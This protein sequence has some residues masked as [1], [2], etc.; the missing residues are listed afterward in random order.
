M[1]A[2]VRHLP[3]WN[4]DR[5]LCIV[6]NGEIYNYREIARELESHGCRSRS[7]GDTEVILNAVRTWGIEAA[8]RKFIGMFAFAIWSPR[9]GK[10]TLVRDRVGVKPLFYW[11]DSRRVLFGSETRALM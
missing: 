5:S 8:V 1:S 3:M 11:S 6:F 7:T 9:E 2:D 4:D 10:L